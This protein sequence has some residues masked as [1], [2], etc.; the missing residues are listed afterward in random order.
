MT[1]IDSPAR[2]IVLDAR[3]VSRELSGIGRFTIELLREL[4]RQPS[5]FRFLVLVRDADLQTFVA[6][7]AELAGKGQ[8]DFAIVP[9][10]PF[11]LR[12]Q[13]AIAQL[14]RERGAAIY[15][16]TNFMI[17]LPA[18]PRRRPHRTLCVC[19]IHDLI[20]LVHPEYTPRA[21]KTRFGPVYRRLM[22]EI[23]LRADAVLTGSQSAKAD[24]IQWLGLDEGRVAVSPDG[25]RE[26]C[27]PSDAPRP[28]DAPGAP[29]TI[30]Y[31]G[32]SDPYKNVPRLVEI[33]ARLLKG[34]DDQPP[35]DLRLRIIGPPDPRYPEAARAAERLGVTDRIDWSGYVS[36]A[37][38]VRAYQT[39]DVLAFLSRYEGFGLPVAEAMACGL[40]V[41]CSDAASLPEVAGAAAL[42]VP[43]DDSDAAESALRTVLTSPEAAAKMRAAGIAQARQFRWK[44]VACAVLQIYEAMLCAP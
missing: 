27:V 24:I 14:L 34:H 6:R 23:A 15:H 16:S 32:R 13:H 43:P 37:D 42:L 29:K 44:T 5:N 9:Y 20:P 19:N 12:G 30:L 3:W 21:L 31:V 28:S 7:E 39:A 4:G 38:L 36:D 33:F 11:N 41:V 25:V 8:F 26:D 22:R 2:R 1:T 40:P 18:F 10:G 35:L 17:P